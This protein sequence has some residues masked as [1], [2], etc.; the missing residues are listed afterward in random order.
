MKRSV[1]TGVA[2]AAVCGGSALAADLPTKAAPA[3]A[4]SCFASLQDYM[5]SSPQDCP[6]TWNGITL[7][8][9]ID[10]GVDYM[11]HGV[12]FNGSYPQGV[13]TLIAFGGCLESSRAG[14]SNLCGV[15]G[16]GHSRPRESAENRTRGSSNSPR[17]LA[18]RDARAHSSAS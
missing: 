8:G 12:P 6:L 17:A 9:A 2:A 3:P 13:E 5:Y 18:G 15:I 1:I 11:T 16:G 14:A 7:Y 4:S 10:M